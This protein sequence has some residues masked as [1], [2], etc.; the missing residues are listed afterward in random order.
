[1][2]KDRSGGEITFLGKIYPQSYLV[3]AQQGDILSEI[4]S[5]ISTEMVVEAIDWTSLNNSNES[6]CLMDEYN[7]VFD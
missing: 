5:Q 2:I 3:I 4:Y 7:T 6:L 1:M